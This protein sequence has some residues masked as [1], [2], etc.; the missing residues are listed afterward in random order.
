MKRTW[1]AQSLTIGAAAVFIAA[2]PGS[3]ERRVIARWSFD[4]PN[5]CANDITGAPACRNERAIP[6]EGHKGKAL[7]FEDWSVKNYVRPDQTE[8]TRL[9]VNES[10]PNAPAISP[11]F[12]FRVTAW[13]FPTADPIYYGGIVE[14]G[15][16]YG[17][18]YRLLLLRG[19]KV[20]ASVG[21]KHVTARSQSP[22][23]L[24]AWHEVTMEADGLTL[25]LFVDGKEEGRA[26]IP[27]GSSTRS[28]APL[29]IGDRFTGRI[30][31]IEISSP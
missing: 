26:K 1:V 29:L 16:G 14:K 7:R 15:Q 30:D 24:N 27:A 5:V 25:S 9:V 4:A 17:A 12:P 23:T 28:V 2:A 10:D 31:E 19:L 22:L 11:P 20:S 18:S 21:E 13:I 8:A 3:A 6:I